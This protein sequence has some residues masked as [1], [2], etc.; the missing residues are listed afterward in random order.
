MSVPRSP[1]GFA[2]CALLSIVTF[3]TQAAEPAPPRDDAEMGRLVEEAL[4]RNPE[5][6][7]T[8]AV[9]DAAAS[10]VSSAGALPDPM[11]SLGYENDGAGISLGEQPMTRLDLHGAAGDSLPGEAPPRQARSPR[12]TPS[13]PGRRPSGSPSTSP[14]SVKRAYADLVEA[15]EDQRLVDEQAGTWK[16]IE[17]VIRARYAAGLG[18]QQDV[19]RAQSE[20][21]RLLQQRT[22]DVAAEGDGARAAPRPPLPPARRARSDDAA[23]RPRPRC[24]RSRPRRRRWRAP[25]TSPPS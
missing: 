7:A 17:E 24:P 10:R 22:R 23:A 16:W 20:K 8:R 2:L 1:G 3:R 12:R 18:S 13:G 11:V 6:T 25:S 4:A 21:T 5:L 15:R 19:L 9:A 14:P